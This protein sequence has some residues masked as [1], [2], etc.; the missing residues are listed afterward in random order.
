MSS[1]SAIPEGFVEILAF[2]LVVSWLVQIG[3][4]VVIVDNGLEDRAYAPAW[5]VA[6]IEG[7]AIKNADDLE[8]PASRSGWSV[9]RVRDHAEDILKCLASADAE[10]RAAALT[11]LSLGGVAGLSCFVLP[12]GGARS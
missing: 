10:F 9:L 6:V 11:A 8:R 12:P 5:A 3:I 4:E 2:G 7:F 1:S